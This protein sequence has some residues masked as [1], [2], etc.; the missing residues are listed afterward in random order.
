M[1]DRIGRFRLPAWAWPLLALPV[2]AGVG[3][4]TYRAIAAGIRTRLES[5]LRTMLASDVSTVGQW[6]S[7]QASLAEMIAADQRVRQDVVELLALSRRTGGDPAALKGAPAQAHLREILGPVVTDRESAGFFV[8]DTGGLIIARIVDERVGD[9]LVMSVADAASQALAGRRAF[10]P[11]T[12]KQRFTSG[13]M[14]FVIVPVRDASGPVIAAFALRIRPEMVT[15]LLSAS[16]FG[17]TG[18]AY[19]LDADGRMVTESRYGDELAQLGLLPADAGGRATGVLEVRDP[20]TRL[21]PGQTPPTPPK[22]WPFTWAAAEVMAG[23]TGVNANGY[24]DYR[25]V[26]VVGA[27]RWLPEWSTGVVTEIGRDE[28]YQT[29]AVVRQSFAVLG[30]G[31]L[32]V[33]TVIALSSRSIYGLQRK[34]QRAER[35]GQYTLEDKIGEGGMGAVYRARHAFLR[36]PTA[37]KL[38]R[39]G[40]ATPAMLSRFEREVQL[41][42]QLTH[43]N[44]IAIYDYGRTPEGIFYYA[45]EYL[46]GLPL[47]RVILDDGPQPEARAVYLLKQIAASLAEAHRIPLVH[48]DMKPANV[49]LCERG[50]TYDVVKVLDFGLVKDLGSAE[51]SGVT[52]VDHVIGTPLFMAP[53]SVVSAGN[54]SPRSD[55]YAVGAIAYAL[56]TG[57]HVFGGNSAAEIIGHHLHSAPRPPSEKLGRAVDPFLDRLVLAC[58][59]KRP[60]DRPADAG[61]L[62]SDLEEGWTGAVWTQREARQWWETRAPAMLAARRAAEESVSRGPKLAVDLSSRMRSRTSAGSGASLPELGLDT[63]EETAVR[64]DGGKGVS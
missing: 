7:A 40:L 15:A 46:P 32:L 49:M 61:A 43:P 42:S 38:I 16:R 6:L 55:V 19:A 60:E 14:A 36:R 25:G 59:A 45:M 11:P 47:D 20:G 35:L 37:V 2:V 18:D 34:V 1:G 33:A 62:L 4:W 44:T 29:L 28:A 50:G 53:E 23:R 57:Q 63:G 3:V 8:V 12:V 30:G 56:L 17:Q 48:R 9:R 5:Y 52:A 51:D 54:V 39:S 27:W 13:S 41:T 58:L 26:E 24:R 10:L 31:L 22:T 21:V 64:P